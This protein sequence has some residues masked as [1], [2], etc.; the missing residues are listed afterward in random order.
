MPAAM[1]TSMALWVGSSKLSAETHN[2]AVL[3][4]RIKTWARQGRGRV[5]RAFWPVLI[6][7]I[8]CGLSHLAA[9]H[10][11]GHPFPFFAPVAAWA[12]L[13]FTSERN[14]R[15]VAET[16]LG[17]SI[18][19]WAGEYFGIIF[20][21]GPIQIGAAI[22]LA[23]ML[24]RFI[25]PGAPFATHTGTQTA[26]LVGL[27]A[28]LMSPAL[29]GGF[30]RWTDALVGTAV[31]IIVAFII[32]SDPR[33]HARTSARAACRELAETL[34]LTAHGL[35][36]GEPADQDIAMNR[37]RSSEI[38]LEEWRTTSLEAINTAKIAASARKYRS[39]IADFDTKRILV[40][41]AMRSIRVIARRASSTPK[42]ESI[43]D[44]A[45]LLEELS[46]AVDELGSALPV[47]REPKLAL[48]LIREV[49]AH[50]APG[51]LGEQN[52]HAQALILVLRSAI[53]DLAEACGASEEE[54]RELLA[55]L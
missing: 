44:V 26:V 33:R 40:D 29:G 47:G 31:A 49:G 9:H 18:G 7:A 24:A 22:F 21:H 8:A 4:S 20:G 41:R 50:A 30:G 39:E 12:C 1:Q 52:W 3:T 16:G 27:P 38:I 19:I 5:R 32:P 45:V 37:G 15:R 48:R 53:V 46:V 43:E 6:A 2:L 14:V 35:R 51:A 23:V 28:G 42:S 25:G 11:L 13:G 34:T 55:P 10:L 36:T 17:L 54:A